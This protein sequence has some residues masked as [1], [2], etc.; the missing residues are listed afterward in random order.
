MIELI[1]A[2]IVVAL[3]VAVAGLWRK[4]ERAAIAAVKAEAELNA[5]RRRLVEQERNYKDV[6]AQAEA[7]FENL[8][9][10]VLDDR[11]AKL[12]REGSEQLRGIVDPLLRDIREFKDRMAASDIASAKTTTE[13][14]DRIA[15]LVGQT[16]AVTSQANNL[17]DAIRGDAQLTGEWGEIQLKRVLDLAGLT[18]PDS[19]TYQ[20]TFRDEDTGRKSSRT[21]FVIKMPGDR[22]LIIDSKNTVEA[23]QR[24][25]AAGTAEER[26]AAI[27]DIAASV[28]R[29]ID[30]IDVAEYQKTVP[31]AFP[32]VLMYIPVEEVYLIAMKEQIP[33]GNTKEFLREYARRH[34]V[35]FVNST[36]VIPVV[37]LVEMMWNVERTEKNRQETIRAAQ[38]LLNRANDFVKDFLAIGDAFKEVFAKYESAK[39]GLVDAPGGQSLTKAVA[40]LVKL[41]TQPKTRTGKTYELAA[42]IAAELT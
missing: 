19:Y 2:A 10:K 3:A 35:V 36:S 26:R 9:Q 31:N 14:K 11:S 22:A 21:D 40:K 16:N 18:A 6:L 23:A 28:R 17:A 29:H 25:H 41:G 38:E 13:L 12:K 15:E 30:E 7:R 42:P 8:A 34:N 33:V 5:E 20:E 39:V 32:T 1:L 24:Y 27:A 37:K 4:G